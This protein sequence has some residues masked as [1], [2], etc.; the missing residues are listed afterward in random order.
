MS[1]EPSDSPGAAPAATVVVPVKDGAEHVPALLGSLRGQDLDHESLFL[2]SPSRDGSAERLRAEGARVIAVDRFDHGETRNLG[3]REARGRVVVFL[4]QDA[5][6]SGPAFLRR[7]TGPLEADAR[8]AGAFARQLP[9]TDADPV[10]RRD[11]GAWVAG[12]A[13]GRVAFATDPARFE[14]LPPLE[15]YRLAVFDNVA[16]AL[17]RDLL[18]AHPFPATRFGEDV[19]WGLRML[20]LGYGLAYVPEAAVVHSH[21]RTARGLYRRHYLGH[22]LLFRL[23]GLRT[24]PDLPHLLRAVAGGV[25]SDLRTLARAGAGPG[26]WLAAPLHAAAAAWGQYRGARDES[27][28]RDYPRWA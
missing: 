23:F 4:S 20:R 11:L 15:R 6:P 26:T 18:L 12:G 14:A 22:R 3:A 1:R 7:L 2:V 8:V 9:R 17:R 25:A 19:E 27:R 28:G 24:V 16:A 21:P 13:A 10:T 5:V